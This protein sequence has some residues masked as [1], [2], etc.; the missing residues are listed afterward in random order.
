MTDRLFTF[1]GQ[2]TI[3]PI[4]AMSPTHICFCPKSTDTYVILVKLLE[5]H[6]ERNKYLDFIYDR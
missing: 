3:Y 1:I 6:S 4:A 2:T 5:F